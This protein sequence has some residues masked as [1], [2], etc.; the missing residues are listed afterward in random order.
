MILLAGGIVLQ[1]LVILSGLKGSPVNQIYFLQADTSSIKSTSL[2]YHNP[3]RWTYLDICGV[4][5]SGKN[6]DCSKK[7]ADIPFD[8]VK[9]FGTTK[10]VPSEFVKNPHRYF[11]LSRVA[12]AFYL[13][14]LAFA[15][16][17]LLAS[18]AALFARLGAYM[19]GL[20]TFLAM[21]C[22][23]VAAALMT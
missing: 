18:L 15:A 16:L 8:P 6:M 14:A 10:G 2:Y 19:S 17:A 12:W 23:A 9:N 7:S 1:I 4:S 20:T 11:Y 5:P 21:I 13:I 22:Q 3:A